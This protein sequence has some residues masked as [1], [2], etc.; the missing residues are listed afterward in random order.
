MLISFCLPCNISVSFAL[1]FVDSF[2]VDF[3]NC[4]CFHSLYIV[5]VHCHV[6]F[7]FSKTITVL[8]E[9][10]LLA[11]VTVSLEKTSILTSKIVIRLLSLF[12]YFHIII[13]SLFPRVAFSVILPFAYSVMRTEL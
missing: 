8:C 1:C 4:C 9:L 12:F 3:G 5:C 13:P 10:L 2:W 6:L 11:A 7:F